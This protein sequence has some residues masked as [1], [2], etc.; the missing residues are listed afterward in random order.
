[1]AL[2]TAPRKQPRRAWLISL[3]VWLICLPSL[4]GCSSAGDTTCSEW[5]SM[6]QSQQS[7]VLTD[8]LRENRLDPLSWSNA[9]GATEAIDAFCGSSMLTPANRNMDRPIDEAIDW[10]SDTW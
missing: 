9:L 1:V 8:L 7:D 10:D 2:D 4:G 5:G 3:A 6:D